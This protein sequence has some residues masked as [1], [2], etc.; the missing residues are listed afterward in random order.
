M[1]EICVAHLVRAKNGVE[2][3]RRF[4]ESYGNHQ[5][6]L[7]HDFLVIFKGFSHDAQI[8]E[9]EHLLASYP[10]KSFFV[11]DRGFDVDAY[12]AV[13]KSFDYRYFCFLNSF[14]SFLD[15]MWLVKMHR[16]I[17]EKDAGLV[18]ATGSCESMYTDLVKLYHDAI[19][20]LP[21]FVPHRIHILCRLVKWKKHFG[22]FPN[23]HIRTNAFMMPAELMRRIEYRPLATKFDA[24]RFES[25]KKGLTSQVFDMNLRAL[26]VG[27]DGKPYEKK[28]W[29]SSGTFWQGDQ[30]N[31][32]VA[33]NQTN[34]YMK[35]GLEEKERLVRLAWG[36]D[37]G[38][39]RSGSEAR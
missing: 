14:S 18:G 1:E 32:L 36:D 27:K 29:R 12:F 33:D 7:G 5:G 37:A 6:G 35:S 8:T 21:I 39:C 11:P 20:C 24:W 25:G 28:E 9:V 30:S 34:I 3:L 19:K 13:A 23:Y 4:L 2:P 16:A 17:S 15:S 22:S 38:V 10:H 31:L 26:V